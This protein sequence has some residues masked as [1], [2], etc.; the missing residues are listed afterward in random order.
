MPGK[1][2]GD[3]S[4]SPIEGSSLLPMLQGQAGGAHTPEQVFAD[5]VAANRYVRQGP[6]KMT[7]IANLNFPS[8]SLLLP[9]QWQLYNIDTDRGETD[10]V[11]AAN[12]AVVQQL[13]QAWKQYADRVDATNPTILPPLAPIDQ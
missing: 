2:Y 10:D 5:E 13:T 7:R 6:W 4:I 9:H 3:R 1:T 11:A 8:A 12:P